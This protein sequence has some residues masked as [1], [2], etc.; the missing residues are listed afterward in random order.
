MCDVRV[1]DVIC[2]K[3][4]QPKL[5]TYAAIYTLYDAHFV[6]FL[7]LQATMLYSDLESE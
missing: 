5:V 1:M 6:L 3:A 2:I 7:R 4:A